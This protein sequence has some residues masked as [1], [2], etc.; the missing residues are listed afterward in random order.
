MR[1]FLLLVLLL[2]PATASPQSPRSTLAAALETELGRIPARTGLYLKHLTTG[3]QIA[4]RADD[5]FNSQSVIKIPIM[6]RAFQLAEQGRLDLDERIPLTRE[7]LRDGSGIL[8]FSDLGIAPTVRDLIQHMVITSD[9][10]ATDVLT[11]RIG[12]VEDLNTWLA[13]SGYKM[14]KLNRGWEYRRKL[15]ARLDPRFA[16]LTAEETTGLQYAAGE[17]PLFAHYRARFAGE[18]AHVRGHTAC[19]G[20]TA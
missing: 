4:I 17:N 6:V 16:S 3:E 10:T 2:V 20:A 18:R 7:L 15:L 13:A 9:N 11:T 19:S 14:R 1:K 12:G 5:S 8:Q